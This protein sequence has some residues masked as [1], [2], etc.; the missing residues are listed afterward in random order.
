MN[1]YF[2]GSST[3]NNVEKHCMSLLELTLIIIVYNIRWILFLAKTNFIVCE[4]RT[5]SLNTIKV[6]FSLQLEQV[7]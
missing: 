3:E 1:N 7:E 4:V 5:L 2:R 6:N